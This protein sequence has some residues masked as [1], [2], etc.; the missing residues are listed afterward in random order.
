M[1]ANGLPRN[2]SQRSQ[3]SQG[4]TDSN[5]STRRN[6]TA[7][8]KSIPA[9]GQDW[10]P[11]G[12]GV[13]SSRNINTNDMVDKYGRADDEKPAR[14]DGYDAEVPGFHDPQSQQHDHGHDDDHHSGSHVDIYDPNRPKLGFKQRLHHFTW[15]WYTLPM[16]TGGLAL[17]IFAQPH[18]FPG[19]RSIGLAVYI[20]NI[21]IFTAVTTCGSARST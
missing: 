16:S 1:Y 17:L 20:I 6:S 14:P 9:G 2:P 19:L 7:S 15:A 3:A 13:M 4:W 10:T 5:Q 21:L 11:L 8:R 18:Q 12:R